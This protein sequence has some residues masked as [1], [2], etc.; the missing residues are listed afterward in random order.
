MHTSMDI[1]VD[2]GIGV[3]VIGGECIIN[4]MRWGL[5]VVIEPRQCKEAVLENQTE[6][7][8]GSFTSIEKRGEI[9]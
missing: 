9:V 2:V 5:G 7:Q 6:F 1:G 8:R 3:Y 4:S